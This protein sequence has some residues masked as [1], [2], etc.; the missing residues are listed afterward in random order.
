[1]TKAEFMPSLEST[2]N[3]APGSLEGG[4]VLASLPGWDSLAVVMFLAAMDKNHGVSVAPRAVAGCRTVDDL[5]R[6]VCS[7][8]AA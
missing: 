3:A 7:A 4:E 8:R 1:M 2:V 5:Y 6:A